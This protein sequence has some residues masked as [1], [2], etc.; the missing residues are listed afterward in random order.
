M[1]LTTDFKYIHLPEP[2]AC[3]PT[4][5][6]D[7]KLTKED[8]NSGAM[9]TSIEPCKIQRFLWVLVE[10]HGTTQSYILTFDL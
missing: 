1:I 2:V 9:T 8:A 6:Q 10:S 7:L 5:R 3:L 4:G